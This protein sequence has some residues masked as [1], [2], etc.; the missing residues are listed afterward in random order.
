MKKKL[1]IIAA[2]LSALSMIA[3]TIVKIRNRRVF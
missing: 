3:L 2:V 1:C